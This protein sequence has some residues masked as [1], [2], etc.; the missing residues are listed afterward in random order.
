MLLGNSITPHD[1]FSY[2]SHTLYA[3][4]LNKASPTITHPRRLAGRPDRYVPQPLA[5]N[6]C[7]V[8][9]KQGLATSAF[10]RHY[11]R[12]HFCFLF[13]RVLRCFTSP[14]SLHTTYTFNGGYQSMTPGGFPHSDILGSQLS[15]QL[16]EAYRRLTRPSSAPCAKA[17]T[18]RPKKLTATQRH[19]VQNKIAYKMLASTIQFTK[20]NPT[21]P[22]PV[23]NQDAAGR[24]SHTTQHTRTTFGTSWAWRAAS[25]PN[26]VPP[27]QT[28]CPHL[29]PTP[30]GRTRHAAQTMKCLSVDV[31]PMSNHPP[32][33][34]G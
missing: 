19:F 2:G 25:C 20:N 27:P 7:R 23:T 32:D 30:T 12:N 22:L 1:S 17:S 15:C 31:P 26:S 5:C 24:T 16:P 8:S 29:V 34:R 4:P 18:V 11:S 28:P 21:P 13:L 14:R 3:A 9:H 6:P 10:A 33:T